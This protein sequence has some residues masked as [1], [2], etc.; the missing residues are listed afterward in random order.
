MKFIA[1][2]YQTQQLLKIEIEQDIYSQIQVLNSSETAPWIAP[3]LVD[4][5][6]NGFG[7]VDFNQ[8]ISAQEW[9][10]ACQSLYSQGC[11]HFLATFITTHIDNLEKLLKNVE[12][13]RQEN[14]LNCVGFHLE[15]P[16]LNPEP[17]YHGVHDPQEMIP[18]D[19]ELFKKWQ[20]LAP[21]A[22]RLITLAPE[23]EPKK[24]LP[25]IR[26]VTQQN[27]RVAI[28][29]SSATGTLLQQA[30]EAGATGWTHL[31]NGLPQE[32]HKFE[33]PIFHALAQPE[34]FCSLIPDGVHLPAHAF[35]VFAKA[36]KNRLLLTTDATAAAGAAAGHY[37]LGKISITRDKGVHS[38]ET[39]TQKLAGSTLTPFET[40]FRAAKLSDKPWQEMWDAYST[41]PA[42][43]LGFHSHTIEKNNEASFCLF[44]DQPRPHLLATVHQG[45]CVGGKIKN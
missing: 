29:H 2:H 34:L 13:L 45:K 42:Q 15:G 3:S 22:I 21:H 19:L 11:T 18:C 1:R 23:I 43:W 24:S 30:V 36:L 31:G 37:T 44:T 41:R 9:Q 25:F 28:G 38:R 4:I 12:K 33:N 26:S 10:Q 5:Q 27:I 35:S 7:R 20:S 14:P 6:I 39:E 40:V 32:I 16:F 8:T 17:G